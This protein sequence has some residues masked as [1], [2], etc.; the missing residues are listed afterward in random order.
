MVRVICIPLEQAEQVKRELLETNS[1]NT[2]FRPKRTST[3]I[4]FPVTD[5]YTGMYETEEQELQERKE[6]KILSFKEA[7][8]NVLTPEEFEIAK[9]AHDIVGSIGIIEIPESLVTKEQ[10]IANALLQSN[11]NIETVV[12]KDSIHDGEFRIQQHK[13]LAGVDTTITEYH[14][15]GCRIL[16][17][18]NEVYFSSRLSTERKRIYEQI[19]EGEEVLVM[20]SGAAPYCCV[21]A[22]NT[23]AK[24]VDGV[25]INPE[26]HTYGLENIKKNKI[27]NV[28]LYCGDV[29]EVVPTLNTIYDR[30]V[31]PLPKL[32]ATFLDVALGVAKKGTIIHLYGFYHEDEFDKAKQDAL[33]QAKKVN[34]EIKI[35]DVIRAGQNSPRTYRIC[36][37]IEVLN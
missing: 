19:R 10:E 13:V 24:H 21:F 15:N 14:E 22:K 9:T 7:L 2:G 29:R 6:E 33:D 18:I 20:F 23:K 35:L 8:T 34:K 30:I 26:G 16:M 11:P 5:S 4:Y 12:K 27:T 28:N 36:I 25:E 1:I 17:D 31:M 3:H 37:D 32:A